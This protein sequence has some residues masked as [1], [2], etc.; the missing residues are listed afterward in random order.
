MKVFPSVTKPG[1]HLVSQNWMAG[2]LFQLP[3]ESS[4]SDSLFGDDDLNK[5]EH[6]LEAYLIKSAI[7]SSGC[8]ESSNTQCGGTIQ[9]KEDGLL[10]R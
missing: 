6:G 2:W 5:T 3:V 9:P 7:E 1:K 10:H 8:V 4:L